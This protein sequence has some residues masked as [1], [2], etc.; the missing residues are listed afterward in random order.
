MCQ[1]H[2]ATVVEWR[3]IMSLRQVSRSELA[4]NIPLDLYHRHHLQTDIVYFT[5]ECVT[6][7]STDAEL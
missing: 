5:T 1:R 2:L 4:Q 7:E 3:K 6:S